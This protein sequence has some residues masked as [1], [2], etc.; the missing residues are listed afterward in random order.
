LHAG[1]ISG[2]DRCGYISFFQPTNGNRAGYIGWGN[3]INSLKYIYMWAENGYSGYNVAQDLVVS[4]TTTLNNGLI[5]NGN[6]TCNSTISNGAS[7]YIFAGG[8]RLGGWDGNTLYNG[9]NPIGIM[10]LNKINFATGTS[11]ANYTTRMTIDTSGNVGIGTTTP[12]CKL[13]VYQGKMNICD[14]TPAAVSN[15][16]MQNGSLTI[17]DTLLNYGG[18]TGGWTTNTAGLLMECADNTEIAIHD[19]GTRVVSAIQYLGG[20][21]NLLKMGRDMGWGTT[22]VIFPANV[23]IGVASITSGIN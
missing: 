2:T 17:G 9:T 18:G 19:S 15:N 5:V 16:Y 11:L 10:T 21:N 1:D 20:T 12:N 14:S 13:Q 6:I 8:L 23:G 22:N 7:S 3:T 4:G